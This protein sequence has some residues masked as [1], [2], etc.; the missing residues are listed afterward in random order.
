MDDEANALFGTGINVEHRIND[1]KMNTQQECT[2]L[3]HAQRWTTSSNKHKSKM[4]QGQQSEIRKIANCRNKTN[5][6]S[7]NGDVDLR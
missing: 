6:F 3:I 2:V 4:K 7:E 1:S 5:E